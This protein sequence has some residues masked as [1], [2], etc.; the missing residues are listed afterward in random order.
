MW[1]LLNKTRHTF[2]ENKKLSCLNLIQIKI[3]SH[4]NEKR[5]KNITARRWRVKGN[6]VR[7]P[8]V[9]EEC[10]FISSFKMFGYC[11]WIY[12]LLLVVKPFSICLCHCNETLW[13]SLE[14]SGFI[15]ET[16]LLS[17]RWSLTA[18]SQV[19]F[20]DSVAI[21]AHFIHRNYLFLFPWTDH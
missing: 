1:N 11:S 12:F 21:Y 2:G 3:C 13:E 18:T 8:I 20:L 17:S 15:G 10:I 7:S 4:L 14:T 19:G 5:L 9:S 6:P 16:F